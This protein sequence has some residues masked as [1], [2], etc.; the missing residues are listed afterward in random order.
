MHARTAIGGD[1]SRLLYRQQ[2]GPPRGTLVRT[3]TIDKLDRAGARRLR[4]VGTCWQRRSTVGTRHRADRLRTATRCGPRFRR[5]WRWAV[6]RTAAEGSAASSDEALLTVLRPASM[7][8]TDPLRLSFCARSSS[9]RNSLSCTCAL[10]PQ[11]RSASEARADHT[12]A[13]VG[14]TSTPGKTPAA[15][16]Q[17]GTRWNACLELAQLLFTMACLQLPRLRFIDGLFQLARM[18]VWRR[19]N[20]AQADGNVGNAPQTQGRG[21]ASAA[22]PPPPSTV[23]VKPVRH[24]DPI[25]LSQVRPGDPAARSVRSLAGLAGPGPYTPADPPASNRC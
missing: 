13:P 12:T 16:P 5:G 21:A 1:L 2:G 20:A 4:I 18:K 14:C 9:N 22:P 23:E 17:A 6:L 3:R 11:C 25:R 24:T 7:S 10:P 19:P 8:C 15:A